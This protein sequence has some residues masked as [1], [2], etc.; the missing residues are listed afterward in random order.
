[1]LLE[2]RR[3]ANLAGGGGSSGQA[4]IERGHEGTSGVLAGLFLELGISNK[5]SL[6]FENSFS[7]NTYDVCFSVCILHFH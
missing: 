7:C 2:V 1:M 6:L 4:V 3:V 5:S